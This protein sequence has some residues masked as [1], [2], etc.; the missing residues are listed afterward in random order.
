MEDFPSKLNRID[1]ETLENGKHLIYGLSED[2]KKIT[3]IIAIQFVPF[4]S[5]TFKKNVFIKS[6]YIP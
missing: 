3:A 2:L 6:N 4:T 5:I 1:F